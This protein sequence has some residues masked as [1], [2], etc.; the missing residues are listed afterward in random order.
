MGRGGV[1]SV[2]TARGRADEVIGKGSDA[3]GGIH[4]GDPIVVAEVADTG[5]GISD[6]KV[7]K[8]FDP[9]FTT[10]PTGQGTGMGLPVTQTIARQHKAALTIQNRKQQQGVVATLTFRV[11]GST[12]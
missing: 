2:R 4:A 5:C 8:I 1:L 12:R 10:K 6:T 7:D 9:F 3:P 11:P